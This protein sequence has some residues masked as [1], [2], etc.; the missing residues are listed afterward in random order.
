VE[1]GEAGGRS[2]WKSCLRAARWVVI[3]AVPAIADAH[4]KWFVDYNLLAPPRPALDVISSYYFVRFCL[5]V[6]PLIFAVVLLDRYL[7]QRECVLHRGASRFTEQ[8]APYFPL[9][10]RVGVS[11]F[12]TAVFVY[13]CLGESMI[14][15][16]ELHTH[17]TWI[18]WF[19]LVIALAVL[20][21]R[22]VALAGAGIV[23]LY[24]YGIIEYGLYHMLD[25]PI[26]LGVAAYLIL[27]SIYAGRKRELADTIIRVA[28]GVTL[29][30]ASIE[31]F[32][33]PEWSFILLAQRP[34]MML[35]FNPEFYMVAAG[36]I[37]FCAAYLLITGLLSARFAALVLLLMFVSAIVPFG[38][39][40]A[41]GHSV[42][43]VVLLL[44]ALDNNAVAQRFDIRKGVALTATLHT[45]AFFATL[46][47]FLALYYAGY[48]A[49]YLQAPA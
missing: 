34:G 11:A 24:A 39:L 41:I 44:L 42:I 22:T 17:R 38:R 8:V 33:F 21:P 25:Y 28:A 29:L 45:S 43:I 4:V 5:F 32:A 9:V 16:P 23:V 30:W 10:L 18:C 3:G 2:W 26:F 49:S 27:W 35:G 12:F 47:L 14:L 31:K 1:H 36:F 37:E 6:G 20:V 15:T 7:T 46:A 40:D 13:G 19:Q 48:Y